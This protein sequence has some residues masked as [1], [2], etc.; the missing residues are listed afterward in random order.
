[1]LTLS[2]RHYLF[3]MVFSKENKIIIQNDYEEKGGLRIKL[4]KTFHRKT[5]LTHL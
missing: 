4:G 5:G 3:T 1:M 2:F